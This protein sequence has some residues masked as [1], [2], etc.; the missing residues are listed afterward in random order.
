MI[1]KSI[2]NHVNWLLA[3]GE[4]ELDGTIISKKKIDP[5]E[6]HHEPPKDE[7]EVVCDTHTPKTVEE[8]ASVQGTDM[9]AEQSITPVKDTSADIPA[10]QDIGEI[11]DDEENYSN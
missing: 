10:K 6:F 3:T 4:F 2:W 9:T 11:P 5:A 1:P 8:V 7:P